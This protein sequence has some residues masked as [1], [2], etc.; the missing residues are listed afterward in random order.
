MVVGA[1]GVRT[2]VKKEDGNEMGVVLQAYARGGDASW[3]NR[4]QNFCPFCALPRVPR[5]GW[6]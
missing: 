3:A 5:I 2:C 6:S 4:T 1:R